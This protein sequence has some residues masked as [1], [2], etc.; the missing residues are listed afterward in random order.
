MSLRDTTPA[1]LDPEAPRPPRRWRRRL[2][3]VLFRLAVAIVAI[4]LA[5]LGVSQTSWFRDWLRR[6]IV[7][8]A[9]RLLDAKVSIARVGGDLLSGIVL[10][11]VRLEQ[12]G[13]AVISIDRIRVTYRVLTLRKTRITLDSVDV[14]RPVIV[15]RQTPEGWSLTRLV[16]PRVKPSGS[17]PIVFAIDALRL[18]DGRVLVEPLAPGK[19]TRIEDLD[20]SLA[21]STGPAGAR[22]EMRAVSMTMPDRALRIGRVV[23]TIEKHDDV[24]SITNTGLDLPRSHLRVDGNVHGVGKAVDLEFKVSSGAFAF[25]EMARLIPWVPVR[26]VQASFSA[27][28][29]GPLSKVATTI[30]FRSAAG[31]AVGDV[32]IGREKDDPTQ[33]IEFRGTLALGHIDPGVWSNTPAVAGRVTGQAVFTFA[34]SSASRGLPARGTFTM[35]RTDADVAGYQARG[36]EARGRFAGPRVTLERARGQAYGGTFDT[37]GT[38]GPRDPGQKGVRFD[39]T[40]RVTHIDVRRLPPPVPRL[41]LAT[42]IAGTFHA[43]LDGPTFDATMTFD[44]STVEGG[45]VTAGSIGTFALAPGVLRYGSK[46]RLEALDLGRLGAALDVRWLQDPRVAGPLTGDV[47]VQAQGRTLRDLTLTAHAVLDR[48]TAAGGVA[49]ATTL[50]ARIADRRLDVDIDGDVA[51]VDPAVA[52]TFASAAGDVSGHVKGHVSIA[53]LAADFTAKSMG[54]AGDVTLGPSRVAGLDVTAASMTLALADGVMDIRRLEGTTP[55]GAVT[56]SGPLA[57]DATATSNLAYTIRGIPLAQFRDQIGDVTGT[58]DVDGRLT[59]PRATLRSAGTARFASIDAGTLAQGLAA[60]SPFTVDLPDWDLANLRL[61]VHPVLSAGTVA[62]MVLE[63]GDVRVGYADKRATFD[64]NASSGD[65]RVH[66][67]GS[68]D[69]SNAAERRI[70]LTTAGL[71]IGEQTWVLDGTRNPAIDLLPNEVRVRGIHFDDGTGQIAEAVGT[72]ALNAP[73]ESNLQVTVRGLDLL[74]IEE[75]AGQEDPEFAGLLNGIA[76]ITGPAG[77]PEVLGSFAIA[78]GR[79]RELQFARVAGAVHYDAGRIGVDVVVEQAPGVTLAVN[80]SV[81]LALFT[82]SETTAA[83]AAVAGGGAAPIDVNIESSAIGLQIVTGLTDA[84]EQVTGTATVKLH[85]TGTAD[86][87]LFDGG[88]ALNGGAFTV[89]ATGRRY[90][91]LTTQVTFEPGRM[92]VDGLKVFDEEGDA[93]EVSGVLGLRR[94]AFGDVQMH[95]QA[96][97]FGFVRND[98]ARLEVDLDLDVTGQ[99]TRPTIV[100]KAVIE[101]GRVEVDRVLA[102]LDRRRTPLGPD[103]AV[104]IVGK[105]QKPVPPPPPP[106]AAPSAT[107][108]A[109][110]PP[111]GGPRGRRGRA[112]GTRRPA[113]AWSATELDIRVQIPENLLLRG[114][115]IRRDSAAA[116]LGDMTL[117]VGGDFRVQK[118]RRRLTTLVGTITTARGSYEYYGRRFEILRDGRIQFTGG[119]EIDPTVDVTARR[120]IEPSGVEARIRVQGTARN[121]TLSFASTPPLDESDILALIIFNRDLNSLGAS[122]KGAVATMAGTAAAG[123]VVSPLADTLGRKLGLEEIDVQTTSDAGTPGGVVTVGDRF[124]ERLFVRLRQQFGAQEVSELLLEYR[125]SELLRLQGAVAEGDGVGRANRSLTRRVERAGLDMVF[126]Y[127]Y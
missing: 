55:L 44:P 81:P 22:V 127:R 97:R 82:S 65:R 77:Q 113:T 78:S 101:Q 2:R 112:S 35:T 73:A 37:R 3:K 5:L 11:G 56:A 26:P 13:V 40:G 91:D 104:P 95:A 57:F 90:R 106:D 116:G 88:V 69:L 105:G 125:L 92:K 66:A 54:F 76:R 59:G 62:G 20:A 84:V 50:D 39:L 71:S 27:T 123:L 68:A 52:T 67:A 10:D 21:I 109:G 80:G 8:R 74:P 89:P 19:P 7:A 45:R 111:T 25:D 124:G 83:E 47:D 107:A 85:V 18:F 94:L 114:Q 14:L 38:I 70:A 28:V 117:V 16:K 61:D 72:L 43:Q 41:R 9:E 12:N 87:P 53:D 110:A 33:P 24:V 15:A 96:R 32:V 100:G 103:D 126:Y 58:V 93:L 79:F 48:A 108:T 17:A 31:D 51:H 6:D 60:T 30:A 121:P 102:S 4:V 23:G 98:L 99:V 29:R 1:T 75:L 119:P 42:D 118:E 34:P 36:A 122:E 115:D 49:T 64:V 63:T 46:A 120:V 86:N